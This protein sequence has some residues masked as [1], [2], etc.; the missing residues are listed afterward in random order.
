M[1]KNIFLILLSF[2]AF[3]FTAF[4]QSKIID[5]LENALKINDD[6]R[7]K[8]HKTNYDKSDT[9]RVSILNTLSRE[10]L[11]KNKLDKGKANA[12]EA[13]SIANT[14]E[15]KKGEGEAYLGLGTFYFKK[16]DYNN[17]ITNF[18]KSK[19]IGEQ[20]GNK[21]A[22]SKTLN[23]LGVIS[24]IQGNYAEAVKYHF[25]A[26]K[27][28]EE[29]ADK[30][31]KADSYN[32]LGIV[33]QKMNNINDAIKNQKAALKIREEIVD[34][35]GLINSYT[36]LAN[37]LDK[38]DDS[39]EVLKYHF[40]GLKISEE[41]GDEVEMAKALANISIV[42]YMQH[43]F[44][45][46]KKYNFKSL[47]IDRANGNKYGI[48]KCLMSASFTAFFGENNYEEAKKYMDSAISLSIEI[49]SPATTRD[50]YKNLYRIDSGNANWQDAY[51]N[52]TTYIQY[53]DSFVNEENTKKVVQTELQYE[54]DKKEAT[55]KAEQQIKDLA[56][57]KELALEALQ[58]EYE[59]KQAAATSENDKQKLKY[60]QKIK[61]QQI[62]FD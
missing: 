47:E 30:K 37:L 43:K 13:L 24:I 12:T 33:Y 14:I 62:N 59:K 48:C 20:I 17:A 3:R 5:S 46:A 15:Y 50:C 7:A 56:L 34:K 19:K 61:K 36:N 39:T 55:A 31:G 35:R 53:R 1:K 23:N 52:Y 27:I 44:S 9:I 8:I 26:L 16:S 45:E 6:I 51:K 28:R 21:T 11:N 58:V 22:L 41:L 2:L 57:Q 54:F 60:D 4:S 18:F 42:Y 40:A 29:M 32:N 38:L 10:L 49:N 25:A